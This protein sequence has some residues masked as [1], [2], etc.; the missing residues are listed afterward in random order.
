MKNK[1]TK[2]KKNKFESN[3]KKYTLELQKLEK[4][5]NNNLN[6]KDIVREASNPKNPL[7]NWFDWSDDEAA[8][9]WRLHQARILLTTIKVKVTF[10]NTFKEYRKYLNV[11]VEVD[12][13]GEG[14]KRFYVPNNIVIENQKMREQI[15]QKAINEAE[16]W[17][18]TYE[19]YKE[20]QDAFY[21]IEKAKKKL[22]KKK[23][24]INVQ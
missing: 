22:L 19:D 7:H 21:G 9:K 13:N 23:V 8:E 14:T 10:G 3:I 12:N 15:L 11:Q 24:L 4:K 1:I 16:Y 2:P 20:L 6:A 18:R 17:R 5:Y